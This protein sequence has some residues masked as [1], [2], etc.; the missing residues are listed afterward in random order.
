LRFIISAVIITGPK[1]GFLKLPDY[2]FAREFFLAF[3][4]YHFKF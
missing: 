4:F 2:C 1:D 3:L